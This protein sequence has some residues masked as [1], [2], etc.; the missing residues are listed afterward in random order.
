MRKTLQEHALGAL[1]ERAPRLTS[2]AADA[3]IRSPR[4]QQWADRVEFERPRGL[5]A[6]WRRFFG[7]NQGLTSEQQRAL[8]KVVNE[9]AERF[10]R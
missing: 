10:G 7:H 6:R 8:E 4:F 1:K 2:E 9:A 5:I 3:I